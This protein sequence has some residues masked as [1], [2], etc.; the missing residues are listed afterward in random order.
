[1]TEAITVAMISGSLSLLGTVVTLL[2]MQRKTTHALETHQAVTDTKID[3]LTEEVRK[4]N[5]FASRVPVLEEKVCALE[6]R[7]GERK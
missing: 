5:N 7:I 3:N 1:M 6:K 2:F 4:H